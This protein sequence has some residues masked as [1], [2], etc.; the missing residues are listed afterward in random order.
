MKQPLAGSPVNSV[1]QL[2]IITGKP[3]PAGRLCRSPVVS[4]TKPRVL[5]AQALPCM[6]ITSA[7][8]MRRRGLNARRMKKAWSPS[9]A[10]CRPVV[11]KLS[12][13]MI[14]VLY[15]LTGPTSRMNNCIRPLTGA[16]KT[17]MAITSFSDGLMMSSTSPVIV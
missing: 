11:C 9:A 12:M 8:S 14:S 4:K 2:L 15:K 10:R 1:C 7:S 5:V 6:A 13:A 17:R 16:L 3:K